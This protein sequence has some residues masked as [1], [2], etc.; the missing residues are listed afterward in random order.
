MPLYLHMV[1]LVFGLIVMPPMDQ[2]TYISNHNAHV[3]FMS[4]T[5]FDG[6]GMDQKTAR[7]QYENLVNFAEKFRYKV[8]YKFGDMYYQKMSHQEAMEK[9][10]QW[11]E[12]PSKVLKN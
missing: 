12:D 4:V 6:K 3:N 1:A 11:N 9:G 8:V 10:F 7:R 2:Q 5:G